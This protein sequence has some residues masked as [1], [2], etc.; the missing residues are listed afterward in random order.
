MEQFFLTFGLIL[1]II[2]AVLFYRVIGGPSVMDRIVAVNMIGTKTA[3]MLICIGTLFGRVDMFV[4][5]ALTY[6][7]LNFVGAIAFSRYFLRKHSIEHDHAD[8]GKPLTEASHD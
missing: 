1:F 5:F 2:M 7:L 4:D 3:I 8:D 6:A